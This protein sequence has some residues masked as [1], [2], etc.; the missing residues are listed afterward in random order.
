[1]WT[2]RLLQDAEL[3]VEGLQQ[4]IPLI[5]PPELSC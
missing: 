3:V 4:A 2:I 5:L 1:M